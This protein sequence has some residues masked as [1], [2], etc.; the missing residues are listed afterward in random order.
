M[1]KEIWKEIKGFENYYSVSS[2]GRVKSL[3]RYILQ[4]NGVRRKVKGRVLKST[5]SNSGYKNITLVKGSKYQLFIHRLVADAFIINNENKST[6]NHKDGNKL[7]NNYENLEW[8]TYSENNIHAI[9]TGLRCMKYCTGE[10]QYASKLSD[11][12]VI[13]IRE[14]Y[15]YTDLSQKE[16]SNM[17]DV[18][19]TNVNLI[20]NRKRWTHI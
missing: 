8:A 10:N 4:S 5:I 1:S 12:D 11:K 9:H 18:S 16:I 2:F 14:L 13:K 6:V 15:K 17:F 20:V 7:N 19:R 3:D